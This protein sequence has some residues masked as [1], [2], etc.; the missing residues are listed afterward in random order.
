V[1]TL[2]AGEYLLL[3]KLSFG[4]LSFANSPES[5]IRIIVA[6]VNLLPLVFFWFSS[7]ASSTGSPPI[8]GFGPTPWQQRGWG[9]S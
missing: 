5:V 9:H 1:E 7:R 6:S 3:K 4:R 2:L 8:P